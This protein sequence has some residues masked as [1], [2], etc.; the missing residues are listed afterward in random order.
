MYRV[1]GRRLKNVDLPAEKMVWDWDLGFLI[2]PRILVSPVD[3]LALAVSPLCTLS[4]AH[5]CT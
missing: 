1:W 5:S 3:A 2:V 4:C